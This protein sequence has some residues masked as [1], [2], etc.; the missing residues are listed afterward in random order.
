M[1]RTSILASA[2]L[3]LGVSAFGCDNATEEQGKASE[4][5]AKADEK[6]TSARAEADD[7]A[8]S[9]QAE[10]DRKIAEAQADFMQLREN[11]RHATT[12]ELAD[13]DKRISDLQAKK[14]K[15]TGKAKADLD[16]ALPGIHAARDRFAADFDN[17]ETASSATW[18]AA[19]ANLDKEWADLKVQVAKAE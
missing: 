19:K 11:Y 6:I 17:L 10:A 15:A 16:A 7:K 12:L 13:L 5:Q 3:A 9:A 8:R 18:D 2:M 14:M 4:A 1:N